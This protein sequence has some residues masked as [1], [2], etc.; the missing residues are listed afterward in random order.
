[1]NAMMAVL[2]PEKA[3]E[4]PQA[5]MGCVQQLGNLSKH[6]SPAV[7]KEKGLLYVDVAINGKVACAMLDTGATH[8]FMDVQ[9]ANRL[10]LQLTKGIGTIKAVNSDAKLV[11]GIAHGVA[12]QIGEWTDKMDF[13]IVPIDDFKVVLGLAFFCEALAFP[14]LASRSLV[15]VD[16]HKIRVVPLKR[17][18][19]S[20]PSMISA[21]QFKRGLKTGPSYVATI[22]EL[23]DGEDVAAPTPT[24]P[25]PIQAVLTKF[26][27]VMPSELP[28]KLPPKRDV[29]H[30]IEL[31]PGA[32][33]P[34]M[35]PYRMAPPELAKLR[36]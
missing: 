33:P 21:L 23:S 11:H 29:D 19:K 28:K 30:H 15:V 7:P 14:V 5:N 18:E 16:A 22:R 2:N 32:K 20:Q 8:N 26:K 35:A 9:E 10:S 24:L 1:M 6:A 36:K 17:K 12:V 25:Q 31:E 13:T 4:E 34:A 27:D 3:N